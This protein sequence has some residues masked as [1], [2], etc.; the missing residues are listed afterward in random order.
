MN[1]IIDIWEKDPENFFHYFYGGYIHWDEYTGYDE[2]PIA[3]LEHIIQSEYGIF[4]KILKYAD[5]EQVKC[6]LRVI[7]CYRSNGVHWQ[8]IGQWYPMTSP[9]V[10]DLLDNDD[11]LDYIN[12]DLIQEDS[13]YR[14]LERGI[15]ISRDHFKYYWGDLNIDIPRVLRLQSDL[16]MSI[17]ANKIPREMY[18]ILFRY[19]KKTHLLKDIP[20]DYINQE[21]FDHFQMIHSNIKNIKIHSYP[22]CD[23]QIMPRTHKPFCGDIFDYVRSDPMKIDRYNNSHFPDE[24]IFDIFA[25]FG[26][27]PKMSDE[28]LNSNCE[29]LKKCN[30]YKCAKYP[31]IVLRFEE[32]DLLRYCKCWDTFPFVRPIP[33]FNVNGDPLFTKNICRQLILLCRYRSWMEPFLDY[34][35]AE[36]LLGAGYGDKMTDNNLLYY[37]FQK[38]EDELRK[39]LSPNKLI[40]V[41]T[42]YKKS[43]RK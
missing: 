38:K 30:F 36:L 39:Y 18:I 10:F 40:E 43:A 17:P 5:L 25:R 14:I 28:F 12:V 6:D 35:L 29:R 4:G 24:Y 11:L 41:L 26:I 23:F 34:E 22:L 20:A 3:I 15:Y 27:L 19:Y 21:L 33:E 2:A 31:Q 16:F 8:N 42:H 13:L 32:K 7:L 9:D 37:L 1:S